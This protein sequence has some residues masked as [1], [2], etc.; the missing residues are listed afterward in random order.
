MKKRINGYYW[1]TYDF[2]LVIII[3]IFLSWAAYK[4]FTM[5]GVSFKTIAGTIWGIGT[6]SF[7]FLYQ[8]PLF[9]N[10]IE[11]QKIIDNNNEPI[12]QDEVKVI[13][14]GKRHIKIPSHT[15]KA[16]LIFFFI[17]GGITLYSALKNT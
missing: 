3:T 14:A 1:T 17:S 7:F 15:L 2:L 8:L 6:L 16:F 12:S 5:H 10:S 11:A 9:G 13:M 4:I